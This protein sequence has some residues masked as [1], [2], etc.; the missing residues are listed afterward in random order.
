MLYW[1]YCK[2]W[3]TS[4]LLCFFIKQLIA[5]Y[6]PLFITNILATHLIPVIYHPNT[7]LPTHTF[8]LG[9]VSY[10]IMSALI[11]LL[12][13]QLKTGLLIFPSLLWLALLPCYLIPILNKCPQRLTFK[14]CMLQ[15]IRNQIIKLDPGEFWLWLVLGYYF[16]LGAYS[17]LT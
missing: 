9:S 1:F 14:K 12:F 11:P 13:Y 16:Y 15:C 6:S 8:L 17:I 7:F 5:F 4:L 10:C 3:S 2:C